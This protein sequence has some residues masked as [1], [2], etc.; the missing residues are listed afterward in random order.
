MIF[1]TLGTTPFSFDRILKQIDAYMCA[2]NR[3][4]EIVLQCTTSTHQWQHS[5]IKIVQSL[6]SREMIQRFRTASH[7][8]TH[9]GFG[10]IYSV[11]QYSPIM[12]LIISRTSHHHEHVDDH[13]RYFVQYC[14]TLV[15]HKYHRYFISSQSVDKSLSEYLSS[16]PHQNI[17]NQYL[18]HG[19]SKKVCK[20]IEE[21][22]HQ[23]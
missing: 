17:C 8:V 18:F 23:T 11:A 6:S 22:I 4:E 9:G 7:I 12:P 16:T 10:T 5:P 14:K 1:I 19:D 13:Q 2:N 15:P 21:F 3:T 20:T